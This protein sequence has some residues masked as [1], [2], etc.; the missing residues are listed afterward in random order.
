MREETDR[1]LR[2]VISYYV[3]RDLR[4]GWRVTSPN[5]EQCGLLKIEYA[6]LDD[7]A[8]ERHWKGSIIRRSPMRLAEQREHVCRVLLDYLR[9]ELALNVDVLG[10]RSRSEF[11]GLPTASDR[12]RG[13]WTSEDQLES[14]AVGVA[15]VRRPGHRGRDSS[16]S[17]HAAASAL[18]FVGPA[19]SSATTGLTL[20]ACDQ[21]IR[22][23][24]EALTIRGFFHG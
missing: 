13:V 17:R 22:E 23:L 15:A 6:S 11:R 5:L 8:N 9:R 12:D 18:F 4:R 3:Y 2:G 24:F 19:P 20:E 1:A 7:T 10:Q 16:T 14:G 21:I